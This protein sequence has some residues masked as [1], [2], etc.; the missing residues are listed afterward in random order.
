[1]NENIEKDKKETTNTNDLNIL[2]NNIEKNTLGEL[3]KDIASL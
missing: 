1:M 2:K 3:T